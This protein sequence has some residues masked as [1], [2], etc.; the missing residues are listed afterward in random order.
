MINNEEI[1]IADDYRVVLEHFVNMEENKH[2]TVEFQ[3]LTSNV[4]KT[5]MNSFARIIGMIMLVI[6]IAFV[7]LSRKKQIN[8]LA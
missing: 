1:E 5:D 8:D 7:F 3:S 6:G 4:P 2:I